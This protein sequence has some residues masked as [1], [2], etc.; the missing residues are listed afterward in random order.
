L[1]TETKY[2]F[3][4]DYIR[5]FKKPFF[6]INTARGNVVKTDDLV[7]A[8]KKGNVKGSCLD[9]LEYEQFSF[10]ELRMNEMPA[11]FQYLIQAENVLLSPH[12]AGWTHES[13]YK[14]AKVLAEKIKAI[15]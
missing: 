7:N 1:T 9:V 2:L 12:V 4:E 6:L 11:A 10:E 3:N 14:L 15:F 8:L 13:K 5:Q